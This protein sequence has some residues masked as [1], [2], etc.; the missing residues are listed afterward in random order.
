MRSAARTSVPACGKLSVGD[1]RRLPSCSLSCWKYTWT[2]PCLR[3]AAAVA[4]NFLGVMGFERPSWPALAGGGRPDAREP[5]DEIGGARAG[6][7]H[8]AASRAERHVRNA[9]VSVQ[10]K[11]SSH[12][13]CAV[14]KRSWSRSGVHDLL[15][16]ALSPSF[17]RFSSWSAAIWA[18]DETLYYD[19]SVF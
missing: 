3:E 11:E 9:Q 17:S 6:W 18:H 12:S 14:A 10:M 7:Q 16:T 2:P 8:E 15:C 13:P 19:F 1:I 4:K 5:Q